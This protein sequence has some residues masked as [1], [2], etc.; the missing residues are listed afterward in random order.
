MSE[1]SGQYKIQIKTEAD[2]SG[3]QKEADALKKVG[4]AA[5][6]AA[7]E[8]KKVSTGV[9]ADALGEHNVGWQAENLKEVGKGAE[10]AEE[11]FRVFGK[12]AHEA[13]AALRV[14]ND[15]IPGFEMMSRFLANGLTATMGIAALVIANLKSK[16][17]DLTKALDDLKASDG[18]RG[19]WVE[20]LK[21]QAEEST[22]AFNVWEDH[23]DRVVQAEQ[24]LQEVTDRG[25]AQAR[26]RLGTESEIGAAQKALAEAKL[27][28]AEKLGQVTPE[29]AIKIRLEIDEAAFKQQVE[30]KVKEIEAEIN[31]RG[32]EQDKNEYRQDQLS[33]NV[34]STKSTADSAAAAKTKNDANLAQDKKNLADAIE[35]QK[36]AQ[37]IVDSLEG[38]GAWGGNWDK[39]DPQYYQLKSAKEKVEAM[40]RLQGGYKQEIA[41]PAI[42]NHEP[43]RPS[44]PPP[45]RHIEARLEDDRR[46]AQ[47]FLATLGGCVRV[48][49]LV[50]AAVQ[51]ARAKTP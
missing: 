25:L 23:L 27:A 14:L 28:L 8:L 15:A 41:H 34:D 26:S 2:T 17:D 19:E 9:S 32:I 38:K 37:E 50:R 43:P 29:Q 22:V 45:A 16:L 39:S 30:A 36:K 3:A 40:A 31:A 35:E 33:R 21:E 42:K 1:Q 12:G 6:D 24:T 4:A 51:R 10:K 46:P 13:H 11:G 47:P 49:G 48:A 44:I 20:K 7:A 5:K 18:A